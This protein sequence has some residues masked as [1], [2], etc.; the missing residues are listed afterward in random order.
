QSAWKSEKFK[1]DYT[2][3][4]PRYYDGGYMQGFEGGTFDK[5]RDDTRTHFFYSYT[6]G[7]Q[8]FDFGDTLVDETI[9][10]ISVGDMLTILPFRL[11]FTQNGQTVGILF[12][13]DVWSVSSGILYWKDDGVFKNALRVSYANDRK[14]EMLT[15][16]KTIQHN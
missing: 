1:W 2:I 7:L 8:Y 10:S 16:L 9:D 12:Y 5:L 4:F 11:D 3:Q 15:I 13:N 14:D 6:N